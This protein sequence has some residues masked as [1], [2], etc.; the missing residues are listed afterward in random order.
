LPFKLAGVLYFTNHLYVEA[1][2]RQ[3]IRPDIQY[4]AF[5][6]A[7]YPANSVSGASLLV[8]V[9][10]IKICCSKFL[11]N[12][13]PVYLVNI[14]SYYTYVNGT[15]QN[16][17]IRCRLPL[18]RW[19]L[20]TGILSEKVPTVF[21]SLQQLQY[22][23]FQLTI[24]NVSIFV[25]TSVFKNSGIWNSFLSRKILMGRNPHSFFS[26]VKSGSGLTLADIQTWQKER[27]HC[28]QRKGR[29]PVWADRTW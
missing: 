8:T 26:E 6:L 22:L 12:K 27:S 29:S 1:D 9:M 18:L 28:W 7:G 20:S 16:F 3:D 24:K 21:F 2:T 19:M 5:I 13:Q 10:L 23:I 11:I 14:F 17:R 15:G 4:P 25:I